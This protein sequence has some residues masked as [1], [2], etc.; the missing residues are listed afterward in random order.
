M[1]QTPRQQNSQQN[2][3]SSAIQQAFDDWRRDLDKFIEETRRSLEAL[4][5]RMDDLNR[6]LSDHSWHSPFESR[7]YDA[8]R[9]LAELRTALLGDLR[10]PDKPG[11]IPTLIDLKRSVEQSNSTTRQIVTSVV[12]SI[13][14][15]VLVAA[16]MSLLK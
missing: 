15:A 3:D 7:L 14:T 2:R 9:Q 12:T 16:V 4:N 6:S 11:L 8:E 1:A 10:T 5:T 13:L